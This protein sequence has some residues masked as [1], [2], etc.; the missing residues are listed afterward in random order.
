MTRP[1]TIRLVLLGVVAVVVQVAAVSQVEVLGVRADL[2]PLIVVA[3]GLLLGSVA[4]AVMGFSMGLLV[5]L[6]LLQTLGVSSLVY[7]GVGYAAGRVREARDVGNLL[8]PLAAGA[9]GTAAALIGFALIQ[10]LLGVDAPVLVPAD[11]RDPDHDRDQRAARA[12][13]VRARAPRARRP[14]RRRP[15][16]AL[17]APA[18][19][20]LRRVRRAPAAR[21]RPPG[22]ACPH[23][24]AEPAPASMTCSTT[25]HA[26]MTYGYR[27]QI[28]VIGHHQDIQSWLGPASP[29]RLGPVR[30]QAH[31]AA[32][33]AM[34]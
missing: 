7:V 2:T 22:R 11:P 5:D 16:Q 27:R 31:A 12:P 13:G 6:A 24:R 3:V 15:A 34:R 29:A 18:P 8:V 26:W 17:P 10:F 9:V 1:L 28:G 21:P 4:G 19:A 32:K 23:D 33:Q 30:P 25:P 14:G 20:A